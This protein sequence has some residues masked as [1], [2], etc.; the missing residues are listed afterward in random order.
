MKP[1][2]LNKLSKKQ[3]KKEYTRQWREA[4]RANGEIYLGNITNDQLHEVILQQEQEINIKSIALTEHFW[5]IE[6]LKKE[7]DFTKWSLESAKELA[8]TERELRKRWKWDIEKMKVQNARL[9]RIADRKTWESISIEDMAEN[10][11]TFVKEELAQAIVHY[12]PDNETA[13]RANTLLFMQV[14][15][16]LCDGCKDHFRAHATHIISHLPTDE[17]RKTTTEGSPE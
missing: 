15:D 17:N 14:W 6:E 10:L 4:I 8:D 1:P 12:F 9:Q 7:L 5:K 3:L 16:D 2:Y 11:H 13:T